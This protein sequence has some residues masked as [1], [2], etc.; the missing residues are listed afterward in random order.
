MARPFYR[1]GAPV[2]VPVSATSADTPFSMAG[3]IPPNAKAFLFINPNSFD[4]RLEG[5]RNGDSFTP[6]TDQT[7]WLILAR[8]T[9]GPFTSKMPAALSAK[10]VAT[11][12]APLLASLKFTDTFIELFYGE[13][14]R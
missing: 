1:M 9:M 6:V 12:G 10:A 5:A 2:R 3:K 13:G 14:G 4:V 8:S 11:Q 7:G